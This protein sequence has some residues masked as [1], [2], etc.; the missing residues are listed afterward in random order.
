MAEEA[1]IEPLFTASTDDASDEDLTQDKPPLAEDSET[2][3]MTAQQEDFD[4]IDESTH[5]PH[6]STTYVSCAAL[7]A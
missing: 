4:L 5:L 7:C 3:T 1:S 2:T 6:Y